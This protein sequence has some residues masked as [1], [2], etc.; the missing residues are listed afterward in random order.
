[1]HC[2]SCSRDAAEIELDCP[3]EPSSGLV[4]PPSKPVIRSMGPR[5]GHGSCASRCAKHAARNQSPQ[6]PRGRRPRHPSSSRPPQG[7]SATR[8]Q[9]LGLRVRGLT[10]PSA[11]Y[12]AMSDTDYERAVLWVPDPSVRLAGSVAKCSPDDQVRQ[13]ADGLWLQRAASRRAP[14]RRAQASPPDAFRVATAGPR[15]RQIRGTRSASTLR[16]IATWI[17]WACAQPA[18]RGAV[19]PLGLAQLFRDRHSI[20]HLF[21]RLR[22]P[23]GVH[24]PT[25]SAPLTAPT[26]QCKHSKV[27][28]ATAHAAL[29]C[30]GPRGSAGDEQQFIQ[31]LHEQCAQGHVDPVSDERQS[32]GSPHRVLY[33][34][35]PAAPPVQLHRLSRHQGQ[36]Q[37]IE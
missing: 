2:A 35:G 9:P 37:K 32:D 15:A 25:S 18:G 17:L 33:R 8:I 31:S 14:R 16:G 36:G 10:M 12:E 26:R 21:T 24:V 7:L 20:R 23:D 27:D 29:D 28:D 1:M 11:H 13:A 5:W 22:G 30:L 19:G 6:R 4:R 3:V 34:Q